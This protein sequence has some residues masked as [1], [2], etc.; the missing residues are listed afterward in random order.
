MFPCQRYC[1][2]SRTQNIKNKKTT[3][4]CQN[5]EKNEKGV[6]KH[7][8]LSLLYLYINKMQCLPDFMQS[9]IKSIARRGLNL[10]HE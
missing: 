4:S 5:L 1:V 6:H 9:M 2:K 10:I 3:T 8:S 7:R